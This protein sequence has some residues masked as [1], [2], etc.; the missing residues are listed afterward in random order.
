MFRQAM[1]TA[2]FKVIQ[3][4]LYMYTGIHFSYEN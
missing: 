1:R 3:Q 4:Q 2:E